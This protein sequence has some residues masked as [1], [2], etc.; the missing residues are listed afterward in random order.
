M[1]SL[2]PWLVSSIGKKEKISRRKKWKNSST[3]F[4]NE[5]IWREILTLN[6]KL[7]VFEKS[8]NLIIFFL[9]SFE[10]KQK[11][12][13]FLLFYFLCKVK[14]K[15][16][17]NFLYISLL[18]ILF[19]STS[20]KHTLNLLQFQKHLISKVETHYFLALSNNLLIPQI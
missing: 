7:L 15:K 11:K 6:W 1:I 2:L 20:S 9:L 14:Q 18:F 16:I 4:N 8:T 10:T 3:H 5:T 12:I 13:I 17:T 19:L